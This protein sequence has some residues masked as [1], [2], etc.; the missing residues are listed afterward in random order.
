MRSV[1]LR[2]PPDLIRRLDSWAARQRRPISRA[3]AIRLLLSDRL[4]SE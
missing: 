4:Q 3:E 1:G 2:L